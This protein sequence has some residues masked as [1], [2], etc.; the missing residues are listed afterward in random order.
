MKMEKIKPIILRRYK[1]KGKP[2]TLYTAQKAVTY[3]KT[4]LE[5]PKK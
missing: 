3:A 5:K 4:N 1:Y 2:F